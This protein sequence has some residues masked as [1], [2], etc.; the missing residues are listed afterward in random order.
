[1]RRI[2]IGVAAGALLV[3]CGSSGSSGS[4]GTQTTPAASTPA[5]SAPV[6]STPAASTAAA[7]P[8]ISGNIVVFAA[9][10][11]KDTFTEL[12]NQFEA[13]NPGTK[14]TL[15]FGGSDTL[16]AQITQGAPVDVFASANTSTMDTVVKANDAKS[17]TNFAKNALEIAV[18]PGNPK[19]ITSL[20]DL[21]KSGVKLALCASSVPCGSA[22]AKAFA[23]AGITPKPV[24][25]EQDV[26]SVLTKV[27]LGEV[28]AGMVYQT[29]VKGAGG[30]VD[31]VDFPEASSAINTYPI[32]SV[33]T[34]KNADGGAAFVA[35]VLSSAGQQVLQAAGFA[36]AS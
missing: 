20:A 35:F 9:A 34:G 18:P 27:E 17:P 32:A 6:A 10:S 5:A 3:G 12:A 31:G 2:L 29:D 16:A 14:V 7:S 33:S 19:G 4:S 26:T 11:L 21:T 30:K 36:P 24:T 23:A 8:S 13:A 25:L 22:A 28:D 1:M 15:S